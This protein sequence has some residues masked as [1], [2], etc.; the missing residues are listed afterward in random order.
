MLSVSKI[1]KTDELWLYSNPT[2]AQRNLH[3]EFGKD[4]ILYKSNTKNKKYATRDANGKIVNFGQL[5]YE[6]FTKH[7]DPKR[8]ENYLRRTE[9]IKGDWEK[10]AYSPNNLSRKIL[11]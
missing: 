7:K 11:W 9:S 4:A 3:K 1:P 8:R 6:D 5:G 2:V 10:N